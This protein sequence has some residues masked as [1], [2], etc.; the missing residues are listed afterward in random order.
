LAMHALATIDAPRAT[1][2]PTTQRT[3]SRTTSHLPPRIASRTARGT[4]TPLPNHVTKHTPETLLEPLH[5]L[6]GDTH[7]IW[8]STTRHLQLEGGL[9]AGPWTPLHH[10]NSGFGTPKRGC[11]DSPGPA[12]SYLKRLKSIH[13]EPGSGESSGA[14]VDAFYPPLSLPTPAPAPLVHVRPAATRGIDSRGL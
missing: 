11:A 14:R 6:L 7:G 2:A 10:S 9:G 1:H 13:V 5:P 12:P 8:E 3:S 4:G